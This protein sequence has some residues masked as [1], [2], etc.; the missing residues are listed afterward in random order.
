M[1]FDKKLALANGLNSAATALGFLSLSPVMELMITSY[2]WR[3]A[4]QITS[5]ILANICVCASLLRNPPQLTSKTKLECKDTS[6]TSLQLYKADDEKKQHC[7]NDFLK[8]IAR[9]FDLSLFKNKRFVCQGM[10]NGIL[11]GAI[12]TAIIYLIPYA[13]SVRI[14]GLDASYLMFSFGISGLVTRF[15]PV[16]WVVD[17]KFISAPTL[18]G[19]AFLLCGLNI[20]VISFVTSYNV[21]LVLS[22]VFG[23]TLGIACT[24][25]FVVV[26]YAAGGQEK[27]PGAIA[28]VLLYEG[29]GTFSCI[30]A[31]GKFYIAR[32]EYDQ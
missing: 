13:V 32:G 25:R 18:C 9:S 14:P 15:C 7:F 30:L 4:L 31:M 19:I 12:N 11:Y 2:G 23:V 8:D 1:F 21:L 16:G 3:G 26:T 28:W 27:G 20:I 22:V 6:S 17:K 10:G 29:I 24:V 5:A